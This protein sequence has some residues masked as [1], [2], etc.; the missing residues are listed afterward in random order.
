MT[1]STME[2]R[3]A[4]SILEAYGFDVVELET[5]RW[6]LVEVARD[7]HETLMRGGFS[8]LVR[9]IRDCTAAVHMRTDE[10]WQMVATWEGC[11]QHA[12]TSQHIVNFA[13]SEWD[14][15]TLVD[16][17]VIL[18]NDPWRGAIH[19]SDLNLLRPIL[20]DGRAEFVLHSTAHVA[21][22]GGAIPGGFANGTKTSFEE[23]LKFPPTLLYAGGVP[24]RPTFNYLL[25]N[26]RVPHLLLGDMRALS[27]SLEVGSRR[28]KETVS[29]YGMD[30]VFAA[31][32]YGMDT[33]EAAMR[34]GIATVPDGDYR[35]ADIIDDDS[36]T[37]DPIEIVMTVRVRGDSM[38]IDYSGSSRQPDGNVGTAWIESTRAIIGAKQ[39][40][41]PS[42]PVNSGTL[43]P[44]DA[45]LPPGSVVCVLPPSSCSNHNDV[46]CRVINLMTQAMAIALGDRAI[47]CDSGH[48][49]LLTIGGIDSRSGHEDSPWATFSLPGGAWGGTWAGDGLTMCIN[50]MG[51]CRSTVHEHAER[52]NPIVVWQH[53]IMPDSAGVG[54]HRG[55]AGSIYSFSVLSETLVTLT[56]DRAR[57]GAPGVQGGGR[58][59]PFYAWRL[60]GAE[61]GELNVL[62]LSDTAP[63]IGV[64]DEDGHPNPDGGVYGLGT[65]SMTGKIAKIVL[66]PGQGMRLVI[67]GGGGWGDPL[68][69]D[70]SS[71]L[72]DI[73]D[74]IYT[75]EFSA[76][77]FGVILDGDAVDEVATAARRAELDTARSEGSWTVPSACPPQWSGRAPAIER[78]EVMV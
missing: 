31:G 26:N 21:D 45:I 64:F 41:D 71:V 17:D 53:E 57:A 75:E 44:V 4:A 56:G 34:S 11:V 6:G 63:I 55:G 48:S 38:E 5:L 65:S 51:N 46:G 24:V 23:N 50:A 19:C 18:V 14:E 8:P 37:P 59:M 42:T 43:R 32:H 70:T 47:G 76:S 39:I 13:M 35:V 61:A 77:A 52:E 60:N 9:D 72:T 15:S 12:F 40:L 25:E 2:G 67:G 30:R 7:M 20:I 78:T 58:G 3:D 27:G 74:G 68:Q 22:L 66:K 36:I 10:G 73:E 29:R 49:A 16:G 54:E 62:E 1:D 33:V 69:R 28:L